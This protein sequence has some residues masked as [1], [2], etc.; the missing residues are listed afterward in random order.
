MNKNLHDRDDLFRAAYQ[1][2]EEE[3]SSAVWE[4]LNATLDKKDGK[5]NKKRSLI[6]KGVLILVM[7]LAG[8]ILFDSLISKIGSRRGKPSMARETGKRGSVDKSNTATPWKDFTERKGFGETG[9]TGL[10]NED[11]NKKTTIPSPNTFKYEKIK[12]GISLLSNNNNDLENRSVTSIKEINE[13]LQFPASLIDINSISIAGLQKKQLP[14]INEPGLRNKNSKNA[15]FDKRESW[16]LTIFVSYDQAGYKLD[17]DIPNN[18]TSIKHRE[19]HEPSFSGGILVTKPLTKSLSLQSGLIF[20]HTM[21]GISP[22]KIYALQDLTGDIAYKYITSS[23]YAFIK[24]GFGPSPAFGDS[25]IAAEGK[26]IIQSVNVPLTVNYTV[27]KKKLAIISGAGIE[28]NLKTNTKVETEV[29]DAAH[30][31]TVFINKL[32]GSK[33][34]YWSLAAQAELRYNISRKTAIILRPSFRRA[35]SPITKNNDVETF[36]YSFGIGWGITFKF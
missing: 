16:L 9:I 29:E 7:L 5:S 6:I 24:P 19:A 36:P 25:L 8:Y 10:E 35:L 12:K 18:I 15:S 27:R 23:G 17:S 3:P 22:Q 32:N 34:F 21:I 11:K 30:K 13:W 4:K 1:R 28:A 33:S 14:V 31:E 20:S 26:H 2:F